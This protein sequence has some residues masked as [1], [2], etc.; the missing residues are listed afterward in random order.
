M[1]PSEYAIAILAIGKWF[2]TQVGGGGPWD[3][4]RLYK[5]YDERITVLVDGKEYI[6]PAE[7]INH[8]LY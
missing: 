7:D 3:Y 1:T 2:T 4:K 5:S 6:M 8:L